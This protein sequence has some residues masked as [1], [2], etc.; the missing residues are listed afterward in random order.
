MARVNRALILQNAQD[1]LL[2]Q[3]GIDKLP[4]ISKDDIQ[5]VLEVFPKYSNII[6]DST[7]ATSGNQT[8]YTTP[9]KG[10]FYLVAINLEVTKDVTSDL[11]TVSVTVP[12][13]GTGSTVASLV[14]QTTTAETHI[15]TQNFPYP[16]KVDK[17]S[18]IVQTGTF[19]AGTAT[20]RT[21]I[22]GL[23]IE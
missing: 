20:K 7:N 1:L 22:I 9:A 3:S 2:L 16:I 11:T 23:L 18:N 15:L 14:M 17:N 19:T 10:D 21:Q 6:K 13:Y 8:V 4:I 5:P 12:L